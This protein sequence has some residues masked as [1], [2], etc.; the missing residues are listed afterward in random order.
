MVH[1]LNLLRA[2]CIDG[3]G[4][5]RSVAVIYRVMSSAY[6]KLLTFLDCGRS[7][8]RML[9]RVGERTDPCGTEETIRHC[10]EDLFLIE[11]ENLLSEM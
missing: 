6:T 3:R 9:N 5:F 11:I 8:S 1:T 2:S 7:L 10:S 4:S